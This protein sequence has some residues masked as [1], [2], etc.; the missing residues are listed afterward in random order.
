MITSPRID[1]HLKSSSARQILVTFVFIL[2]AGIVRFYKLEGQS[3]WND[4]M[5]SLDVASSAFEAIQP[6]LVA[7]YHHPP[8]FF[9]IAHFALEIFGYSAWALRSCSALFGSLTVGLVFFVSARMFN[10]R[11]GIAAGVLCLVAPFHIAYSQEGRPYALA[12][13][14]CLLSTY[15]LYSFIQEKSIPKGI[16]YLLSTVALL[17]SHH[18]GLFVAAAHILATSVVLRP[19]RQTVVRLTVLWAAILILYLPEAVALRQ[20]GTSH[21]SSGWFWVQSPN[22]HTIVDLSLAFGG[23]FFKMASST[24]DS[25]APIK[26][27]SL[28]CWW[29]VVLAGAYGAFRFKKLTMQFPIA[30]TILVLSIPFT[31]AF[32]K[33]E[34]FLWYRYTVIAFP[35][36]CVCVGGVVSYGSSEWITSGRIILRFVVLILIVV[37][38]VGTSRYFSWQK[39][40]VR[41]VAAYVQEVSQ[42]TKRMIIRPRSFAPLLNYYYRGDAIQYDETYLDRPLGEI[43]DTARS[44]IYVTLDIP[45]S[46]R[47]YMD[48]HFDKLAGR[49]FPG[50]AHMG[51]VVNVYSQKPDSTSGK[52]RSPP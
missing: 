6:A 19:R 1:E 8:L 35:L 42:D 26:V 3:L 25:P 48:N 11:S 34:V 52:I 9:Y 37:G 21:D 13:F 7:H 27:L 24:F 22:L 23:T 14:L 5:F 12:G 20:Q 40:N 16:G 50:N 18:W 2:L 43:V 29:T 32:I 46:I 17:Y 47:E 31:L 45:N 4:E 10:Q 30:C 38:I 49:R 41:E 44:F 51:I 28:V 15:L 33:P 39:S 36:L